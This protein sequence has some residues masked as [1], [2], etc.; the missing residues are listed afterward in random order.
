M[1][2]A[3]ENTELLL[4]LAPEILDPVLIPFNFRRPQ[5]SLAYTRSFSDAKQVLALHFD[6]SPRYAQQTK[7]HLLPAVCVKMPEVARQAFEMTGD[8]FLFGKT[9][10][11]ISHQ[12]QNL[13]P[14]SEHERWFVS[15]AVSCQIALR[16]IAAFF[17][18]WAEPFLRDY[19]SPD[20]LI[21]QYELGDTRPFQTDQLFVF[22][23]ACYLLRGQ[24]SEAGLVLEKHLGKPGLKRK[25]AKAFDFVA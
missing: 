3:K 1:S 5:R 6:N 23:A 12:M 7:M 11:V 24:K 17:P 15:D 25:Y 9:E 10:I 19:T 2:V 21:R 14:K 20:D 22:I 8:T 4:K 16:E 18:R 13:A